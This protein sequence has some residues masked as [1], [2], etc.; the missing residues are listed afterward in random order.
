[1]A[2]KAIDLRRGMGVQYQDQAWAVFSSEHVTKG[3]GRSYMQI[4][5]K[6]ART[7]QIIKQRFRVDEQLEEAFFERKQME[8]LYTDGARLVVMD[9]NTYD[10]I[11]IP[12]ELVGD[13][14][15]YLT[16]SLPLE[17]SSVDGQPVSVELPNTVELK[18]V[19]TPPQVKGATATAQLKDAVCEG[20]AKIKV[21][22]FIENGTVVKVD[23]RTGEYLGRA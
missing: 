19:D 17:V 4:A 2:I 16:P 1:M 21:P 11:E 22:P 10:Q 13:K 7:G 9:P 23:T 5:L 3:K 14:T 8:Y 18:V 12:A 15:V 6:N 20:G